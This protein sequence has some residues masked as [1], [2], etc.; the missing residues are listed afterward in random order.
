MNTTS[1]S[2]PRCNSIVA[3]DW[4][5][6]GVCRNPRYMHK[7]TSNQ[8]FSTEALSNVR[9]TNVEAELFKRESTLITLTDPHY[10]DSI[11]FYKHKDGRILIDSISNKDIDK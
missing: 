10:N 3:K 5:K 1:V 11:T 2:C 8:F 7:F 4:R 6:C 9:L